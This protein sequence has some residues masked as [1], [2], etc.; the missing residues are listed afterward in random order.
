MPW[1]FRTLGS[2]LACLRAAGFE[3]WALDEP[4]HPET[5]APLSLLLDARRGYCERTREAQ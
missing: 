5:R 4:L 2:W 3:L 1:Y